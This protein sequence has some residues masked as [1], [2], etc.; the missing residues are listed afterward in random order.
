[1]PKGVYQKTPEQ[2]EKIRKGVLA[3]R[4]K[5]RAQVEAE[6]P[7]RLAV[8]PIPA[9][10]EATEN[11]LR[12]TQLDEF[13]GAEN[14]KTELAFMIKSSEELQKPLGHIYL[15]GV[16]GCGKSS[17]ARLIAKMAGSQN[18]ILTYASMIK[19]PRDLRNLFLQL[20]R[21]G[22]DDMGNVVGPTK[23]QFILLDEAHLL[24]KSNAHPEQWLEPL[25]DG[26][27]TVKSND[28]WTGEQM[29]QRF[30]LPAFTAIVLSNRIDELPAPF[31]E[32]LPIHWTLPP[33][34]TLEIETLLFNACAK[35]NIA[36]EPEA[37]RLIASAGRSIP[38]IALSYLDRCHTIQ[39]AQG[40][41]LVDRSL[42]EEAFQLIGIYD[43]GVTSQEVAVLSY[44]A[45]IKPAKVGVSRLATI[46]NMSTKGFLA[47]IE[48]FLQREGLINVV[49]AGRTI[50]MAG[51]KLLRQNK[52]LPEVAHE[53][54]KMLEK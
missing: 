51:I 38:R 28:D 31:L 30:K 36:T 46:C 10:S 13:V 44:L 37:I 5:Q 18:T 29:T 48:P 54:L 45:K 53:G 39:V 17:F 4:A 32:R 6:Q 11:H 7:I 22:Y 19:T 23:K 2:I 1:M 52:L 42:V 49:P 33:Y 26:V 47:N 35:L 14:I 40:R 43:K 25:E 21:S 12:P 15:G 24:A 34:E 41:P 20:D 16:A 9:I 8:A 3:Y 27:F 50:S